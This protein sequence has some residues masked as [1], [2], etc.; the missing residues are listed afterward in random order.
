MWP[1]SNIIIATF[2]VKGKIRIVRMT[3]RKDIALPS[4]FAPDEMLALNSSEVVLRDNSCKDEF[5]IINM[6][7]GQSQWRCYHYNDYKG[8]LEIGKGRSSQRSESV[9]QSIVDFGRNRQLTRNQKGILDSSSTTHCLLSLDLTIVDSWLSKN[10]FFPMRMELHVLNEEYFLSHFRSKLK[11]KTQLISSQPKNCLNQIK[12]EK[13]LT[14]QI[15]KESPAHLLV[16]KPNHVVGV[17]NN[18]VGSQIE[19]CHFQDNKQFKK[20]LNTLKLP[21]TVKTVLAGKNGDLIFIPENEY[22]N[23]YHQPKLESGELTEFRFQEQHL[24][25]FAVY[26]ADNVLFV[27][28]GASS[29]YQILAV[30][31]KTGEYYP[32]AKS[33]SSVFVLMPSDETHDDRIA[34]VNLTDKKFFL[35][36]QTAPNPGLTSVVNS[37]FTWLVTTGILLNDICNL[38]KRYLELPKVSQLSL[39]R[40]NLNTSLEVE[41]NQQVKQCCV[42]N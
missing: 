42:I 20:N 13:A 18:K 38:I 39:F 19:V 5:L 12:D 14:V 11:S 32:V 25:R 33:F 10:P 8:R 35:S 21:F 30:N 29:D 27:S 23:F 40:V 17:I 28:V 34:F 7:I 2:F 1:H 24:F 9:F 4:E 37:S 36:M 41:E 26:R 31:I 16:P 22:F 3:L 15:T 6:D